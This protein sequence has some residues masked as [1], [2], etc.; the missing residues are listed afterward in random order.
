MDEFA[1]RPFFCLQLGAAAEELHH[2]VPCTLRT[3]KESLPITPL[4]A[5][6]VR[7]H[8][9]IVRLLQN[10]GASCDAEQQAVQKLWDLHNEKDLRQ[11]LAQ[12][13]VNL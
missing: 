13:G 10:H 11:T 3:G 5:A 9:E 6:M 8:W 4:L 2:G 12:V 1:A 7:G